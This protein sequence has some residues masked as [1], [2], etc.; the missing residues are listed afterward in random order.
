MRGALVAAKQ[1]LL[2]EYARRVFFAYFVSGLNI[3]DINVIIDIVRAVGMDVAEFSL[4]V[5]SY[6]VK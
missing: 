6:D 1:G 5:D 2:K 4:A 3:S